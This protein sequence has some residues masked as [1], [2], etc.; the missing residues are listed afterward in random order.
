MSRRAHGLILALA[1]AWLACANALASP[2]GTGRVISTHARPGTVKPGRTTTITGT[3][4]GP[5]GPVVGELLELQA[6]DRPGGRF[7]DIAHTWTFAG[8][9][10]R[11][12]RVRPNRDTRYRVIDAAA[13][14]RAGPVVLVTVE[15]SVY[16]SAERVLAAAR[17]LAGRA[18]ETAFALVDDDG[19]LAGRDMHRRFSSASVVKAMMLVAYLQMLA[20]QDRALDGASRGL[21][22]PM[23]HSSDNLAASSVLAAVGQ[24]ALDEVARE[25]GM[26]DYERASG[27]WA[28]TQVSAAD[29]ARF[30]FNQDA[31]IPRRFDWYAR[32]LLSTIAP[33]QSWGIPAIARPQFRVYFKGGWL[34]EEGVVNQAGRLERPRIT[35]AMAVLSARDP[36]IAYGE[37][38]IGGVT[39]R[40]LGRAQ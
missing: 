30:F 38:T 27:W 2:S 10:Y 8:G 19:R 20:R 1:L 6:G 40:L 26:Q 15:L 39:A 3:L 33:G 29:L 22:Y 28:L 35:F 13:G 16:P 23:I 36:S 24:P 9:R 5:G 31:L 12:T 17:Y 18:G 32:Q 11:F 7:R 34:P 37:P 21:L 25:A 14:N 4:S